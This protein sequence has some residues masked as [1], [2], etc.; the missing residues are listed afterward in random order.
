LR[1]A[2]IAV[3]YINKLLEILFLGY[4][5]EYGGIVTKLHN[6]LWKP[7]D[8]VYLENIPWFIP[9]YLHTLKIVAN[10]NEIKPCKF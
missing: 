4:G 7:L 3:H 8:V 6:G 5:Q 1:T 10:G 9:L 2:L